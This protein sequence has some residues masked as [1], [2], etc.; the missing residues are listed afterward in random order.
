MIIFEIFGVVFIAIAATKGIITY[1]QNKKLNKNLIIK[2]SD[3]PTKKEYSGYP[4]REEYEKN[5]KQIN[6]KELNSDRFKITKEFIS[7]LN[8]RK[9]LEL[10]KR[11]FQIIG[12]YGLE[13]NLIN[14]GYDDKKV[15]KAKRYNELK[16][17]MNSLTPEQIHS[18]LYLTATVEFMKTSIIDC[19]IIIGNLRKQ[20]KDLGISDKNR[21]FEINIDIPKERLDLLPTR[22][23]EQTSIPYYRPQD[24][25]NEYVYLLDDYNRHIYEEYNK[26]VRNINKI[27]EDVYHLQMWNLLSVYPEQ[28]N[29]DYFFIHNNEHEHQF[30]TAYFVKKCRESCVEKK[31]ESYQLS[32]ENS[33]SIIGGFPV[34]EIVEMDFEDLKKHIGQKIG[35]R[36]TYDLRLRIDGI[37]MDEEHIITIEQ[38]DEQKDNI[39]DGP[40]LILKMKTRKEGNKEN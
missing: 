31:T 25:R 37:P 27:A 20:I 29:N 30:R 13:D 33:I 4:T 9:N 22:I 35:E 16:K 24:Y 19:K 32:G 36:Q 28:I 18:N 2:N 5:I 6:E 8:E 10:E 38:A 23:C 14:K 40:K 7:L 15:S 34:D 11:L 12:T 17:F 3:K 39:T 26:Y 21:E 1:K